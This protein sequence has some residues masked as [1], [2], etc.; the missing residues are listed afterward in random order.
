MKGMNIHEIIGKY[1]SGDISEEESKLFFE[2]LNS[3]EENQNEF[4]LHK[5][6]WQ[7]SRIK[8]DAP[9][10]ESV[11]RNILN[12]IDDHQ[13][14]EISNPKVGEPA[15]R[16]ISIS[17]ITRIAASL[18]IFVT[19]LYFISSNINS[20]VGES[21]EIAYIA[22]QNPS[23]QKSKIYL[24]DGS[25]VWLN[26]E[27]RISFPEFFSEDVR[28]IELE[29]EAFFEVIKKSNHPFIVRAGD[30]TTTVLGTSFNV[31]SFKGDRSIQVALK[32]G[33][34]KVD[35]EGSPGRSSV[36]LEPGEAVEFHKADAQVVKKKID[37][38]K[39]SAWKDGVIVF[40]DADLDEIVQTL[41]RWYGVKIE[42]RNP[43]PEAW[44]YNG[45]FDNAILENVL[46]SIS[47]SEEF[48]YSINQKN[49]IINFN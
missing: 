25:E 13:E 4:K 27:S 33:K 23:G 18:I 11:F 9:N 42:V 28:E 31:K 44:T 3:S 35:V 21:K 40:K 1:L 48:S 14:F 5:K 37:P 34:V 6:S 39:L 45:A 22:K 2:W 12:K 29:G 24:P 17:L 26:A 46:K 7:A 10:S 32:R 8:F 30:L 47:F 20:D 36:Y 49:V 41:S 15:R 43:K 19:L 16:R 38:D